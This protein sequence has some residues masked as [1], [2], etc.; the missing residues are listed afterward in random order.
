MFETLS[1]RLGD[2]FDRLRGA[3]RSARRM[4]TRRCARS[5]SRCSRP[6]SPCRWSSDFIDKVRDARGRAGGA[7]LGHAGADGGQDRPRPAD[8]GAG[9]RRRAPLNLNAVPPV[10]ILMVGLQ[11]S[12]KTTTAA[13]LARLRQGAR[14]QEG[15][16]RLARR[17]PP[18]GAGTARG[19]GRA[20]PGC[21]RCRSSPARRRSRS[22]SAPSIPARREVYDVVILDT[23]GRLHIDEALMDEVAAVRDA[24]KPDRDPAG[25]RCHD[26]PG[27]GQHRQA[28]STSASASPASC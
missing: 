26:R 10:P 15:A 3:A 6:T 2:T 21:H 27:R 1:Q 17:A 25:G 24:T 23:A 5:A 13:K 16:A 14:A 7:A 22:P 19:A 8:R 12:G 20:Q 28:R 11:G 18:G 9:R 4:S